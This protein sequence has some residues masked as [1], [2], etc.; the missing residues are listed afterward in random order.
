MAYK[1]GVGQLDSVPN[2]DSDLMK[3]TPLGSGQEVGRSCHILQFKDKKVMLDCGIHPGLT[4]MDALPFVDMIE[5]D[6]IDLLLISHFHLDHA[7]ALP[8]FLQKTTF[9]GKCFM[10][11]ATKAIFFWL[12]SDYIKVSNI[13][14]EQM[15]YTDADLEAAMDKIETI[16]F[17]EE[18]EVSG[19]KFWCYNAGHVLGAAMFMVEIAGVRIL[20]TGDFSREEDRHL[21]SAEIP[22]MRPDVLIVESTYGTH[23]HEPREDRENRFTSTVADIVSRGGRCLIPVFALGRAQELLLILDEYWS[24]HPE[25]AEVPIFYASS[26]AKKCMAVYQTFVNS[27]NE[28]IRRQIAV[29]NPFVFKH[30]S[31]LKGIDHFDDIGPCVV[32][33]SPGMMQSGLSRELFETWC[34]DSKNGCIVAGYCV[35]GTLAKHIL[36]EP[37]EITAMNG[38]KLPLNMQ[39]DYISFSAHTDYKQT[40]GFIRKLKPPHVVL[41]HGEANE[42]SRLKSALIREYE[43]DPSHSLE[44]HNPRNTIAVELYFRGEKMAKVMGSLATTKPSEGLPVSGILV[45]RN[46]TYHLV[47][48]QDLDKYTDLSMSTV[49]QRQSVHY[50]GDLALLQTVLQNTAGECEVVQEGKVIRAFGAVDIIQEQSMLTLEWIASP[51]ADMFADAVLSAIL[52]A[53]SMDSSRYLSTGSKGVDQG[54]FKECLIELLQDMF[55]EEAVPKVFSGDTVTV[56]VDSKSAVVSLASLEVSCEPQDSTF[57]Q[58]V[59]TAVTKLHHSLLANSQTTEH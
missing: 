46:F 28:R 32:L 29:N 23:I 20:Y 9:K 43:A 31:N 58:I 4:G 41:V 5:A 49:T 16:N 45:K 10:T 8:W 1:R 37:E 35:E 2:E 51:T 6:Q 42:M 38:Q 44:V 48:P 59:S 50:S 33:A 7:G 34:T 55:G 36:S 25:L 39:V 22:S 12:L 14:T 47:A 24:A 11:H 56:S 53:D 54:H 17:H 57:Q 19:V 15:L 13:S 40:S 52:L 3:I 18:K 30:I 26:L 27:M 21:M